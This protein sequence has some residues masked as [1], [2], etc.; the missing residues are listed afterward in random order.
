[1]WSDISRKHR[2]DCEWSGVWGEGEGMKMREGGREGGRRKEGRTEGRTE[3]RYR[4]R[5]RVGKKVGEEGR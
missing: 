5:E 2:P 3:G 4:A 1:M